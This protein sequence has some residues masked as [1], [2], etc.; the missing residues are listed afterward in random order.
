M[1]D[2]G[3]ESATAA[4]GSPAVGRDVSQLELVDT[5]V[6]AAYLTRIVNVLLEDE[7]GWSICLFPIYIHT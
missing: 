2:S 4:G 1:S 5:E 7:Q 6:F 3:S